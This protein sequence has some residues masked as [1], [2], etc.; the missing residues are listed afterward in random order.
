MLEGGAPGPPSQGLRA[1]AGIAFPGAPEGRLS[2]EPLPLPVPLAPGACWGT[3]PSPPPG[4]AG[5][6]HSCDASTSRQL[7]ARWLQPGLPP[8]PHTASPAV[9]GCLHL[10]A[11]SSASETELLGFHPTRASASLPGVICLLLSLPYPT[12][13]ALCPFTAPQRPRL[14]SPLLAL[15]LQRPLAETGSALS[16]G[17]P[18]RAGPSPAWDPEAHPLS[19]ARGP[20][21]LCPPVCSA[22]L[23]SGAGTC[24]A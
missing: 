10:G 14:P 13:C 7:S 3:S 20:S 1:G 19:T 15:P 6:S 22:L 21:Q 9:A 12:G 5:S 23:L 4:K 17:C 16:Y 24:Q 18:R 2:T 8:A 11:K